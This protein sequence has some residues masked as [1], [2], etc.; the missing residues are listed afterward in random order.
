MNRPTA[1][2]RTAAVL[3]AIALLPPL[4]VGWVVHETTRRQWESAARQELEE[5]AESVAFAVT[6]HADQP[7]RWRRRLAN[8]AD[9][10]GADIRVFDARGNLRFDVSRT[11]GGPPRA[12]VQSRMLRAIAR[13]QPAVFQRD[14]RGTPTPVLYV[15]APWNRDG[16]G[17]GGV[18][19]SRSLDTEYALCREAV[20][21]TVAPAAILSLL[22][23][24]LAGGTL[25]RLRTSHRKL[26]AAM[27]RCAAGEF[28]YRLPSAEAVGR[29]A[30][31]IRFNHMAAAIG[32]RVAAITREHDEQHAV[33]SSIVEGVVAVDMTERTIAVNRAAVRILG[34][35]E[36]SNTRGR[37]LQS[38]VR[39]VAL[40]DLVASALKTQAPVEG[41]ILLANG[42]EERY[43]QAHGVPLRGR[44][45]KAFGAVVGMNDV[46]RLRRLE[47]LRREFAANVSHE[48]KTPITSIKGFVETLLDGAYDEREDALRFLTIILEQTDRLS[49]IIDDLLLLARI[50]K[51]EELRSVRL[52]PEPIRPH[53]DSVARICAHQAEAKGIELVVDCRDEPSARLNSVLFEQA[54]VNLVKNAITYSGE[55]G[56]VLIAAR[57]L[58][59]EEAVEVAVQD[60]GAGIRAEHQERLFERFYR[61]DKARS[62]AQGG[63]GLGLAIVKHVMNAHGGTVSLDSREG[64]G[65]IFALRFPAPPQAVSRPKRRATRVRRTNP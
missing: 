59:A 15:V 53:L 13:G 57:S 11:R 20:T 30:I 41:D 37:S 28:G 39:N 45:G 47:R 5:V 7:E 22:G 44:D 61:V 1:G 48:L 14:E 65:S 40:Q 23:T 58:P 36:S 21:W 27:D 60:W 55:G 9:R 29:T 3:L 62:R 6:G 46:T 43:I 52:T 8:L 17:G 56:E 2:W 33:L 51:Q 34:L 12:D 24:G 26:A 42:E 50:E 16:G 19:V 64:R 10:T 63:T 18:C 32:E 31:G 54:V 35:E 49:A 25:F 38:V 4:L